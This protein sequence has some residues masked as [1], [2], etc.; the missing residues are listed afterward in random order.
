MNEYTVLD[1]CDDIWNIWESQGSWKVLKYPS[2]NTCIYYLMRLLLSK[3]IQ[4]RQV[5]SEDNIAFCFKY[6]Y[7][8]LITKG[9]NYPTPL[10]Q[11]IQVVVVQLR[12]EMFI[13]S[14]ADSASKF[15]SIHHIYLLLNLLNFKVLMFFCCCF[16][17]M[18]GYVKSHLE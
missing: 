4:I 15:D 16:L 13:R 10:T 3:K 1:S 18:Y 8:K 11:W 5:R 7:T 9:Q 14:S 2:L 17:L 12:S 6:L